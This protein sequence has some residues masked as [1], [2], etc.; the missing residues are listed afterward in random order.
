MRPTSTCANGSELI[1]RSIG[2]ATPQD[3]AAIADLNV[4]AYAEFAPRVE[5]GAWEAMRN[6]L[7]SVAKRAEVAEFLVCRSGKKIVGSVAYCRA[8]RGDPSFF[9]PDMAAVM[10]LAVSPEERD[11]GVATALTRACIARA[12]EDRAGFIALY[13]SELMQAAQRL[14]LGLGFQLDSELPRRY[15]LR[16]FRFVLTLAPEA[17]WPDRD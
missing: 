1:D 16:Y 8:G 12:R 3:F 10:M 14:Y 11:K 15:G 9:R 6:N 2:V 4:R 13:T 7:S 17:A 5:P